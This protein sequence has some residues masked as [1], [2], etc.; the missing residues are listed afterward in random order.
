MSG[1]EHRPSTSSPAPEAGLPAPSIKRYDS[2]V[3]SSWKA[4]LGPA[5]LLLAIVLS[6]FAQLLVYGAAAIFG[7]HVDTSKPP[8]G[9]VI[10]GTALQDGIFVLT[11]ALLGRS[12]AG[13]IRS[14]QLGLRP[15]PFWRS[16][17]LIVFMLFCFFLF[18]VIWAEL[19]ETTSKE[20]L[21]EQLGTNEATSL[22]IGSALLTCVIAPI[23]EEILFRG[24]IFTSLRNWR[25]PWV[26]AILT[27]LLFGLVHG[28]SAPAVYLLPLAALGFALCLLYRASGSLYPCIAAHAINN[29]LAFGSQEG[30]GWQIPV[31][32]V[33][34]LLVIWLLAQIAKRVGLITAGGPG[35]FQLLARQS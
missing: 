30:W 33:S 8:G 22:L 15:T 25:G 31:L 11:A 35:A 19:I 26:S 10:A 32:L 13:R 7:V 27:G 12:A 20:K 14:W 21:L 1:M 4:W 3:L 24:F 34:A 18:S 16:A 2:P 9:V 17:L 29:S 28:A 6:L 23:C 5:G